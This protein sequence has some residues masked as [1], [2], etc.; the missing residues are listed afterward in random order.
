MTESAPAIHR[1]D[2]VQN[3][4]RSVAVVSIMAAIVIALA[5]TAMVF[6]VAAGTTDTANLGATGVLSE[7]SLSAA[8]AA[9]NG[10]VQAHLIAE[11]NQLYRKRGT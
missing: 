2:S 4:S 6:S 1:A 5:A 7:A 3:R 8:A 11:A 9:R 10:V